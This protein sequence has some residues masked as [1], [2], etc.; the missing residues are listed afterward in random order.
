MQKAG[1]V[2][3]FSLF[4]TFSFFHA[5]KLQRLFCGNTFQVPESSQGISRDVLAKVPNSTV[6]DAGGR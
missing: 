1:G 4:H 3:T 2:G 5:C 6:V